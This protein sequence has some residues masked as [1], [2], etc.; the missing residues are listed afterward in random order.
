MVK[1]RVGSSLS[2]WPDGGVESREYGPALSLVYRMDLINRK[3]KDS[4]MENR[5]M[6]VMGK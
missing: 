5:I 6:V 2:G 4:T 1:I 3:I